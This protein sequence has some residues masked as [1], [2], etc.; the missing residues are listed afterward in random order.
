MGERFKLKTII[1]IEEKKINNLYSKGDIQ[2]YINEFKL[3]SSI[4]KSSI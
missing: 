2:D 3:K 4:L 1:I